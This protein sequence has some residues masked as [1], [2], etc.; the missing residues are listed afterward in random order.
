MRRAEVIEELEAIARELEHY[1]SFVKQ[2]LWSFHLDPRGVAAAHIP[3]T[4]EDR[5]RELRLKLDRDELLGAE[6][7]SIQ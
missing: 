5:L 6:W 2:T 1:E 3:V 7:G 4:L